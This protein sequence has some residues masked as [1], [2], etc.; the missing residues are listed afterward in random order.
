[1]L[2]GIL[3]IEIKEVTA[4]FFVSVVDIIGFL[5]NVFIVNCV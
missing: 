3:S 2:Y 1:M 4:F 5:F